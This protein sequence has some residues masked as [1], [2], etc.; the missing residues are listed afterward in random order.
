M[1]HLP[2]AR[3]VGSSWAPTR[4]ELLQGFGKEQEHFSLPPCLELTERSEHM[5]EDQVLDIQQV[6]IY[7]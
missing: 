6:Q 3:A 4:L 1:P 7:I 5:S 2:P